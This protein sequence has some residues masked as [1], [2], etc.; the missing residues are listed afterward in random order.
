MPSP[1]FYDGLEAQIVADTVLASHRE[2]RWID[3]PNE[4]R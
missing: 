4:P 3:I 1:S 2:R